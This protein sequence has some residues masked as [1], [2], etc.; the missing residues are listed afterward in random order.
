MVRPNYNKLRELLDTVGLEADR[1]QV[2]NMDASGFDYVR[3]MRDGRPMYQNGFQ[4]TFE[5]RQWLSVEIWEQ[6]H[7]LYYGVKPQEVTPTDE[8]KP[9]EHD[10]VESADPEEKQNT[11]KESTPKKRK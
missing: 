11:P 2:N 10:D 5:R 4:L 6:V 1:I 3:T 7:E 8:A 9:V